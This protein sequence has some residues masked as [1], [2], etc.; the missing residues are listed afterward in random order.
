MPYITRLP[1][2][3]LT[4]DADA[5]VADLGNSGLLNDLGG[6]QPFEIYDVD[7]TQGTT[8]SRGD[9]ISAAQADGTPVVSGTYAGAGVLST[10]AARVGLPPLTSLVVQVNPVSGHFV[11]GDDG[12]AYFISDQPF[13]GNNLG[14]TVSGTLLGLP[15][16]TLNLP[17]SELGET[18]VL[19]AALDPVLAA[20]NNILDTVV[21]NV[22]YDPAGTLVLGNDDVL[23]CFAAGTLILTARGEV[24]VEALC[25][26]DMVVTR[27]HGARPIRWAGSRRVTAAGLARN[28][29]LRPIRI[30][31]GALGAGAPSCDL[32]VSPQHR[33]LVRSRIAQRMFGTD[34]VLVAA[35]QLLSLEGID[36][37]ED[38]A[39]VTYVHI[40]FDRH[41]VVISNGAQTESLY[42]GPEALKAVGPAAQEEILTLFPELRQ[43]GHV[44]EPARVLASGRTGRRL[45]TRHAQQGR[46][47]V[48]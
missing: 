14:V 41:E 7:D 31:A 36:I 8:L 45:A 24:P 12:N 2:A 22:D 42:T 30:R 5:G 44:T 40:L 46:P 10:A 27:D 21:V 38:V 17:L 25:A 4:L 48:Q 11:E 15:L 18:P 37:A 16:V 43:G 19:G 3:F 1:A 13:D 33:I 9:A 35:K 39:G 6:S 23:P 28:P 20:A 26:G 47:L 32:L 34:E 29:R